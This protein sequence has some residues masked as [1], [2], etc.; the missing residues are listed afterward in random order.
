VHHLIDL[1]VQIYTCVRS[2]IRRRKKRGKA[3]EE[4][5]EEEKQIAK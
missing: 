4:E 5:K 1:D 2:V 3:T